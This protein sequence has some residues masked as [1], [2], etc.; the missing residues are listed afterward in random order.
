M[1]DLYIDEQMRYDT[2]INLVN[3][4]VKNVS[5]R[6]SLITAVDLLVETIIGTYEEEAEDDM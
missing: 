5:N 6:E 4:M 3:K 2:F 1:R